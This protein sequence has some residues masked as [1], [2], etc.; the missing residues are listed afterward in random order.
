MGLSSILQQ[1]EKKGKIQQKQVPVEKKSDTVVTKDKFKNYSQDRPIDPVVAR[2]KEKRRLEREQKER[3]LRE[4]KGLPPKKTTTSKPKSSSSSRSGSRQP[5]SQRSRS[6]SPSLAPQP[7]QPPKKK[8]NY[9]EL[10]K[11]AATIDHN[12]LSINLLQKSKSPEAKSK[13][14]DTKSGPAPRQSTQKPIGNPRHTS[15]PTTAYP[16][17]P[18]VKPIP[19]RASKPV[20]V[21]KAP[22][23]PRQPSSKIKQRLEEKRKSRSYEEVEEEDDL[24]DFVED[25]EEYDDGYGADEINREEIWAMFNKGKKRSMYYGDDYDSDDME[26]TGAEIFDEEYQSR[27]DAERE[28]RREMEEEKRLQALKRKRLNRS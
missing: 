23:P 17:K 10:L 12:K 19:Q 22:L 24:S 28:D 25:D 11:K 16:Q 21:I 15:P 14:L 27:L 3:E 2:L 7:P 13:P 20:P 8:L 9:N 4:K 26:A 18:H 1:I 6:L 5:S